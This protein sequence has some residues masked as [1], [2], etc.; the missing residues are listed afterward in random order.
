MNLTQR[1]KDA[2][3]EGGRGSYFIRK[4]CRFLQL[5]TQGRFNGKTLMRRFKKAQQGVAL[6]IAKG[7]AADESVWKVTARRKGKGRH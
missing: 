7:E 1:R 2:K 4:R 3:N 5:A 6:A